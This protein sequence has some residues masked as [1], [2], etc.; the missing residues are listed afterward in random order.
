MGAH[1]GCVGEHLDLARLV[2]VERGAVG[3][4][5]HGHCGCD[6]LGDPVPIGA[7]DGE[8]EDQGEQL[9]VLVDRPLAQSLIVELLEP[10]LDLVGRD[11]VQLLP[12]NLRSTRPLELR[13]PCLR[14][15]V[16]GTVS[17]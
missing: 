5:P 4:P 17:R 8:A 11:C 1:A 13:L 7:F 6:V 2:E 16:S 12:P 10:P 15:G 3:L 14:A 9:A